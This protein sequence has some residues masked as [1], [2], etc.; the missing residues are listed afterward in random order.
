MRI[1]ITGASGLIGTNLAVRL[2]EGG[3]AVFGVDQRPNP[4]EPRV[5]VHVQDLRLPHGDADRAAWRA[6]GPADAVVHLAAR[7][8]VHES[9]ERPENALDNYKITFGVLEYCRLA[10]AERAGAEGGEK[11]VPVVYGSSRETYGEQ[12]TFPVPEEAVRLEGAASPYA[13]AKLADE[14]LIRAYGRCYGLDHVII[15]YS[16]VYGRY[17]DYNRLGRFLP[18]LFD[19]VPSGETVPIYGAEKAYD[20]TYIDDAVDGTLAAVEQLVADARGRNPQWVSG[21]AINLGT[22]EP[23]TLLAAAEIVARAA[24]MAPRLDP[25]PMRA[26]EISRYVADLSKARALLGYEPHWPPERGIPAFFEWWRAYYAGRTAAPQ[27]TSE[28]GPR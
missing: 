12:N 27:P 17:D 3:H 2:L 7:A 19:R 5:P 8:K 26:G 1:I 9:V 6:F 18:I 11:P 14:A 24:G 4:W 16:N 20:F 15:R 13:A 22:G 21:H 23:T 28:P 10:G 25:Q